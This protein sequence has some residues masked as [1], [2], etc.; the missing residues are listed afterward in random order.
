MSVLIKFSDLST[1]KKIKEIVDQNN[2]IFGNI[3]LFY[4]DMLNQLIAFLDGQLE[5]NGLLLFM[6]VLTQW[7]GFFIFYLFFMTVSLGKFSCSCHR[8][9]HVQFQ[10]THY[11]SPFSF[12]FS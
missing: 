11:I 4:I 6:L 12:L 3:L 1:K 2:E 5:R 8:P 7:Q 10:G 9:A